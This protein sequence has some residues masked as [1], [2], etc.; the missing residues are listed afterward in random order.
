MHGINDNDEEEGGKNDVKQLGEIESVEL[1][2]KDF[3]IQY[4]PVGYKLVDLGADDENDKACQV[5]Y[6]VI[7]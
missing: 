4:L 1:E 7:V 2:S 5:M 3:G 6:P